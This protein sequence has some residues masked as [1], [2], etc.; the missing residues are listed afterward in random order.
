[1]LPTGQVTG[2]ISELP[3]V[4]ELI[5]RIMADAAATLARLGAR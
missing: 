4:A 5:D 2:V 1:V 3:T